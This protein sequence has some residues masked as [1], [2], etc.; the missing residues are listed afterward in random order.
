MKFS[1]AENLSRTLRVLRLYHGYPQK[2]VAARL[3]IS[4]TAYSKMERGCL[5]ARNHLHSLAT[6]YDLPQSD[7]E[8][9][10]SDEVIQGM[11]VRG[12]YS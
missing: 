12:P 1:D 5:S 3:G 4:Q 10:T 11:M 9:K 8:A 7:L 2:Y 6:V